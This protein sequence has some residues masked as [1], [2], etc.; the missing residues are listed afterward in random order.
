MPG[1]DRINK[2]EKMTI[3]EFRR[4]IES[5]IDIRIFVLLLLAYVAGAFALDWINKK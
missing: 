3:F 2:R 1:V 4:W 5:A